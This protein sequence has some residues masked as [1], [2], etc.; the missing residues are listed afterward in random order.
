MSKDL[1]QCNFIGRLGRDPVSKQTASGEAVA[2]FSIA[3]GDDYKDK[4]GAKI[5]RTNWVNVVAFGRLAEIC[6]QYLAKGSRVYVSG[7]FTT[8]KWQ[9]KDGQDRYTTE[10]VASEMQML[11]SKTRADDAPA[12]AAGAAY[13]DS[14]LQGEADRM[15]STGKAADVGF[16][17]DP[18][19]NG[20][21][22]LQ[23]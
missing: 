9:T 14:W 15:A 18:F 20:G 23:F 2:N 11:D 1:N 17:D 4:S 21:D 10:I 6:D 3:V 5:D 19:A 22:P 7:K 12:A 13:P 8:R 16:D